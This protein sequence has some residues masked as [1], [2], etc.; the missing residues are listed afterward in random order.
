MGYDISKY[1]V[2][3]QRRSEIARMHTSDMERLYGDEIN[4]C[5][6]ESKIYDDNF[7]FN[8]LSYTEGKME[9]ILEEMDSVSAVLKYVNEDEITSVLNFASY[10]NPGGQFING[11]KAQ[12]E[13]LCHE[14]YLYNVLKEFNDTFYDWNNKHKNKALYL[15]R[16]IYSPY[17]RFI[18]DDESVFCDVLTCASPNKTA[19]CKYGRVSSEEN[20]KVLRDR[21]EFVLKIAKDNLVGNLILGA[22]GCGVFGQSPIEVATIFKELLETKYTC[23]DKVIFAIP[24]KYGENYKAF[25]KVFKDVI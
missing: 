24:D 12:E 4:D 14:S 1:W 19:S 2:N 10:K 22:Y 3:K 18:R 23:F 25:E 9:I 11:S 13:C 16:A 15:N 17:V 20:S 5:A 8:N 21:I 6:K 7:K